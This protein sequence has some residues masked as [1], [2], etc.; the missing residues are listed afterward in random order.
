MNT[1]VHT[2]HCCKKHGCKYGDEWCPVEHGPYEQEYPCEDC[3][4]ENICYD[5]GSDKVGPR[6]EAPKKDD[7]E[8]FQ[9][10]LKE[11]VIKLESLQHRLEHPD[12]TEGF[13][14]DFDR[15]KKIV[16]VFREIYR[17][18]GEEL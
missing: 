14:K 5:C 2:R 1:G 12:S 11:T 17:R 18:K 16:E 15:A 8:D 9:K 13:L 4:Y 10:F 3:D 7:E 6:N